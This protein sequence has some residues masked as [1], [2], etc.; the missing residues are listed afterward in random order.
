M[1]TADALERCVPDDMWPLL[2]YE[3][4]LFQKQDKSVFTGTT[5]LR[6]VRAKIGDRRTAKNRNFKIG[7]KK[8]TRFRLKIILYFASNFD[9]AEDRTQAAACSAFRV[10]D[11]I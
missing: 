7:N 1:I 2:T 8:N 9:K 5:T 4:M 3:E 11:S 10:R 6:V